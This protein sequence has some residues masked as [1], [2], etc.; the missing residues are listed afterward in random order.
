MIWKETLIPVQLSTY[1][2]FT[3]SVAQNDGL[4]RPLISEKNI[5]NKHP[6]RVCQ[7]YG[8]IHNPTLQTTSIYR[9]GPF[10]SDL[11]VLIFRYKSW[12][13]FLWSIRSYVKQD[14][15]ILQQEHLVS[16]FEGS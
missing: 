1:V 10:Y 3:Y 4:D 8:I 11:S 9:M 7:K 2:K 6:W 15:Y 13:K 5:Q 14:L 12:Y 16:K